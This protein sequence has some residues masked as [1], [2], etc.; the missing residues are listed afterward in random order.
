MLKMQFT[1]S[2]ALQ[3][4]DPAHP[5]WV[6]TDASSFVIG[7]A[8]I[9][10]EE[11]SWH[12]VAYMLHSLMRAELNLLVRDKELYAIIRAFSSWRHWLLPMQHTIKV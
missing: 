8:L 7:V 6:K 11:N 4:S 2:S 5:F 10:K 9:V 1:S 12:S 3:Y